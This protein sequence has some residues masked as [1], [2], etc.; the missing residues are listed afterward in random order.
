MKKKDICFYKITTLFLLSFLILGCQGNKKMILNKP[1]DI[2]EYPRAPEKNIIVIT[3]QKNDTVEVIDE[4]YTK[5]YK[6]YRVRLK[7]HTEGYVISESDQFK[8]VDK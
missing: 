1:T 8:I 3:L 5:E 7:D 2:L 4:D 6:F